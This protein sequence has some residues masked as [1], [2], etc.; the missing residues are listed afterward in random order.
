[1]KVP[2]LSPGKRGYDVVSIT[3]VCMGLVSAP[4]PE[5]QPPGHEERLQET[6]REDLRLSQTPFDE[7]DRHFADAAAGP[8]CLVEHLHEKGIAV[9]DHALELEPGQRF[10]AP[11]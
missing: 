3:T 4:D 10:T 11:A 7:D 8:R 1:M 9:R 2:T 6:R 5:P